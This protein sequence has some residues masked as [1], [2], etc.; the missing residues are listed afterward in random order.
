MVNYVY[1]VGRDALKKLLEFLKA[2]PESTEGIAGDA[3]RVLGLFYGVLWQSELLSEMIALRVTLGEPE[4]SVSFR[5]VE[6]AVKMLEER[7]IV[8]VEDRLRASLSNVRGVPDKLVK[9]VGYPELL[10]VLVVDER[11]QRYLIA[12]RGI[13]RRGNS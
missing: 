11:M 6:R 2:I 12:R 4:E 9:L 5:D 10:K 8:S 1:R 7:G 3:I 13:L